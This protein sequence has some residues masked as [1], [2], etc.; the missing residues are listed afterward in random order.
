MITLSWELPE[1]YRIGALR[2]RDNPSLPPYEIFL[3]YSKVENKGTIYQS[4]ILDSVV[5]YGDEFQATLA[6]AKVKLDKRLEIKRKEYRAWA[7]KPNKPI[8]RLRLDDKPANITGIDTSTL[9]FEL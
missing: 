7:D 5:E 3:C 6:A 8:P 4:L 9:T 2:F 1:G